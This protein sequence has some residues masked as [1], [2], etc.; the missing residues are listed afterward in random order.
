MI[1]GHSVGWKLYGP[2]NK[3]LAERTGSA[4]LAAHHQ[5]FLDGVR[6]GGSALNAPVE[7]G[8]RAAT[9]VHLANIAARTGRSLRF[10]PHSEQIDG[11]AEAAK[12]LRRQYREHWS[13]P[14]GVS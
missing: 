5:N 4:D 3:L 12:L 10:D 11:D 6:G 9:L 1:I 13:T 7:A 8:H 2:R 14:R